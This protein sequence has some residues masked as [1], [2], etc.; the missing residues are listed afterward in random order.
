MLHRGGAVG[1]EKGGWT[2]TG[3]REEE[4]EGSGGGGTAEITSDG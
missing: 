3:R 1:S 2:V 4:E